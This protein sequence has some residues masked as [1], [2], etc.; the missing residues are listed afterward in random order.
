MSCLKIVDDKFRMIAMYPGKVLTVF[1]TVAKLFAVSGFQ[2]EFVMKLHLLR[3]VFAGVFVFSLMLALVSCGSS[4]GSG[5]SGSSG[6]GKKLD[7]VYHGVGG[8]PISIT[9]KNGKA[10]VLVGNESK[11]LDYKVDGNKL[12]IVNPAEGDLLLTINDDGTLNSEL[13]VLKKSE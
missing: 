5:G 6:G 7:G 8:G 1:S 9:I 11:T 4:G 3:R 12:T 2:E 13:G 10:T